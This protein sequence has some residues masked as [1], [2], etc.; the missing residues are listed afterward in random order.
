MDDLLFDDDPEEG[1]GPPSNVLAVRLPDATSDALTLRAAATRRD[2]EYRDAS[3]VIFEEADKDD[4]LSF[5]NAKEF[6]RAMRWPR[7][8]TLNEDGAWLL[9]KRDQH[10]H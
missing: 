10:E 1:S 8:P 9:Q 6:Q 3:R 4:K 7:L 2:P 5:S